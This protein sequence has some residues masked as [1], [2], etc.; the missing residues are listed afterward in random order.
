MSKKSQSK[1]QERLDQLNYFGKNL[2]RRCSAQ[3]ELCEAGS[4]SLH[5]YEVEPV[6]KEPA[7]E[8]CLMICEQCE[9][10]LN[11][12]KRMQVDHW[13]CL[14]KTM[15]SEVDAAKVVA[16]VVL[17]FLADQQSWAQEALEIAYLEDDI[18][19][20]VDLWDLV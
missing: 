17:Q 16:I 18:Q 15:W 19:E 7:L 1:K 6:P 3:C 13:R 5:I 2:V 12:V 9:Q 14:T 10:N 8:H 4:V 11:N 20:W